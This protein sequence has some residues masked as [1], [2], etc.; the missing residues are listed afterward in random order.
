MVECKEREIERKIVEEAVAQFETS[1]A[2]SHTDQRIGE[3]AVAPFETSQT[4]RSWTQADIGNES[5]VW[6]RNVCFPSG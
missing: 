2:R 3:E 5:S 4:K 6:G 1:Q